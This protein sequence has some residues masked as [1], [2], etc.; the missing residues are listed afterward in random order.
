MNNHR[1][2]IFLNHQVRMGI[3]KM[4]FYYCWYKEFVTNDYWIKFYREV[5]CSGFGDIFSCFG[6][7][8]INLNL[9]LFCIYI[10]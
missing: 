10:F 7:I 9:L 4:F 5:L 6:I 2:T 3:M 8:I 1:C